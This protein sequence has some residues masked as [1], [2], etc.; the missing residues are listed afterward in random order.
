MKS[1]LARINLPYFIAACVLESYRSLQVL[2]LNA[3]SSTVSVC[4]MLLAFLSSPQKERHE[5][6]AVNCLVLVQSSGLFFP[7]FV[8]LLFFLNIHITMWNLRLSHR[9]GYGEQ[10]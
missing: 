7:S 2:V 4:H 1:L 6:H 9:L 5:R 3:L 8:C 10:A